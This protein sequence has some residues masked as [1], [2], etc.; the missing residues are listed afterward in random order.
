M[1]SH[2]H[3]KAEYRN[4]KFET[5]SNT[6]GKNDQNELTKMLLFLSLEYLYFVSFGFRN[7]DFEFLIKKPGFSV[8]N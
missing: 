5:N 1:K 2:V 7:S 3:A 6:K 4:T 8:N